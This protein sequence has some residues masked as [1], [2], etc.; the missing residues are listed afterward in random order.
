MGEYAMSAAGRVKIG[1]CEDM[2][3]L[4]WDQVTSVRAE[5]GSV[6]PIAQ[7]VELR[8]RFPW[9]DEDTVAVGEFADPFRRLALRDAP[10]PIAPADHHA[11]QFIARPAGYVVSLPCP[12]SGAA[13][14]P[15]YTIHRNGFTGATFLVQQRWYEGRLVA[16][17]ECVC[18]ARWRLPT[19]ADAEPMLVA[20]RA[21]ADRFEQAARCRCTDHDASAEDAHALFLRTVADRAE[22]GY[23]NPPVGP[24]EARAA[25]DKARMADAQRR[26]ILAPL[27]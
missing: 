3:Y 13:D 17:C 26:A 22:A 21:E 4:R 24:I 5:R 7:H 10:A 14:A 1:T 23:V 20:L 8:F 15:P 11:I 2:L 12:E 19:L 27:R 25:A 18:G 9:P 6:D 16:V